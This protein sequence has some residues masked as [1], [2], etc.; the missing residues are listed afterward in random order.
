MCEFDY[1]EMPDQVLANMIAYNATKLAK[2]PAA[3]LA[4]V[5]EDLE[6]MALLV[7]AATEFVEEKTAGLHGA[8]DSM[9]L[10]P[11]AA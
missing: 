10:A 6:E 5:R 2:A 9:F 8:A 4:E 3:A 1:S 11:P 7:V